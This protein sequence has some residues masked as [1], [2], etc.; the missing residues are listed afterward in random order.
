M[1]KRAKDYTIKDSGNHRKFTTGARRDQKENK[2]RYD[3]LPPRA[4]HALAVHY[5]KGAKKYA[6][7]N[8]ELGMPLSEFM[9]SGLRHAFEDLMN[10]QDGE[11]HLIAAIW[12]FMCLYELRE[13]IKEGLLPKELDDLPKIKGIMK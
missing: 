12:N 10:K 9:D 8:W 7:R 5:Q 1:K 13:R 11:N 2:G 4:V 3:L 6:D